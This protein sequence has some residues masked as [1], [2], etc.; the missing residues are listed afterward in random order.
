MFR[1]STV[2]ILGAG[3]SFECDMPLGG[4][5]RNEIAKGLNFRFG[6]GGEMESGDASL[7]QLLAARHKDD[8]K[9][10]FQTART[11][12]GAASDFPS[13]DE[14]LHYFRKQPLVPI[15]DIRPFIRLP[16]RRGQAEWALW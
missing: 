9:S 7:Y 5:L 1:K 16:R 6:E 8:R 15:A 11:I 14:V 12:A 3:A 10:M 13:I 2:I 4:T